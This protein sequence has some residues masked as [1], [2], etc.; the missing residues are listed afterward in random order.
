MPT[1]YKC[2]T[3]GLLGSETDVRWP[4][5]TER[6]DYELELAAVLGTGGSNVPASKASD[7]IFGYTVMNDFSARDVQR[8]EMQVRLGPAKGKD[9]A[10]ALGPWIVTADEI[11]DP[12]NLEMTARINGELWSSG[13]SR[14]M[15]WS[16]EQMIEF[17]SSRRRGVPRRDYWV[18]HRRNRLRTRT[19]SVDPAWR[20]DGT[21][22]R[23]HRRSAKPRHQTGRARVGYQPDRLGAID[24]E[25]R[26]HFLNRASRAACAMASSISDFAPLH[27]IPPIV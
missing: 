25:P 10:T 2:A 19:R 3:H 27:E 21:R 11:A 9:W 26:R 16:F 5:F 8:R 24:R 23:A 12:R 20:S 14:D 6:F 4:S 7:L 22:D 1:Y 13:N 17:L 15:R 18:R